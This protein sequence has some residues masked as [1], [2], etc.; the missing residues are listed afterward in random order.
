MAANINDA[1]ELLKYRA[2][3]AGISSNIAPQEF[4]LVWQ[5]NELKFFNIQYLE[6]AVNQKVSDSI[7]KWT[8]DPLYIAVDTD[9]KYT[10]PT[11]LLHVDTLNGFLPYST[12]TSVGA[13]GSFTNILPGAGYTDGSYPNHALTG[14][15][16]TGA[17]A[18]ITIFGGLVAVVKINNPGS[19]YTY[20]D[21]LNATLPVG[22]GFGLQVATVLGDTPYQIMRIE[23]DKISAHL[24]S[25][26]DSPD[27]EFPIYSQF[28]T[29]FQ[30]Y[31]KS[32][33]VAQLIYLKQPASSSWGY[34]IR[35]NISTT[36]TLVGG[37]SYTNNTYTAVALTGGLGS[38]ATANITVSGGSVTLVTIVNSGKLYKAGDVL[39]APAAS[40]GGTGT[41]F[42]V[43][44]NTII[45]PRPV[46]DSTSSVQPLWSDI[47]ISQIVDLALQDISINSRDGELQQF[48]QGQSKTQQ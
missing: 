14:G 27:R 47:D 1:F 31:P 46:Y 15:T 29:W 11:D 8:S 19:G 22:S 6:Y 12:A 38:G 17:T 13:I 34:T 40:I 9:G 4:N 33:G 48:A 21:T 25:S 42:T 23:K 45:N 28:S 44:V 10:F 32:I 26:Y 5:R 3:Q 36:R 43:T 37:S 24:S 7:S 30:F 16:G 39:S 35:G 20:N 41:G 2:N 18:D